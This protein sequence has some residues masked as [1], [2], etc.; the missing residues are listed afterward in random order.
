MNENL[1]DDDDSTRRPSAIVDSSF[2]REDGLDRR[3]GFPSQR[4][5]EIALISE[6]SP[7]ISMPSPLS[8]S[9]E[10]IRYRSAEE[11]LAKLG[12]N[13]FLNTIYIFFQDIG[14]PDY[15]S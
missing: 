14:T 2:H 3:T 4:D 7:L 10:K 12:M 9:N 13:Y 11:V 5:S 8:D 6:R 15:C 1:S